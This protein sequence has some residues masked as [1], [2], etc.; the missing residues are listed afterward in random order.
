MQEPFADDPDTS[1]EDVQE[2]IDSGMAWHL[3]GAV[4]RA[5]M[6]AIRDGDCVLGP[7]GHRDFYGNYVPSLAEVQP[8]TLGSVEYAAAMQARR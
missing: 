3:E 2:L 6:Q 1:I 4:G 8:G 7:T 5:C